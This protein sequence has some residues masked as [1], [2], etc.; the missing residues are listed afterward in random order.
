MGVLGNRHASSFWLLGG[1]VSR[2]LT[3]RLYAILGHFST[4]HLSPTYLA[5]TDNERV[6]LK[7]FISAKKPGGKNCQLKADIRPSVRTRTH[8]DNTRSDRQE[9]DSRVNPTSEVQSK[10]ESKE[11]SLRKSSAYQ[12]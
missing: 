8:T 3:S 7:G 4:I 1:D 9:S 2:L 11:G 5:A 10:S 6:K 12:S